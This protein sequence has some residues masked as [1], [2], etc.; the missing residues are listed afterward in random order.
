MV[1]HCPWGQDAEGPEEVEA[2]Q[3]KLSQVQ[4]TRK[5]DTRWQRPETVKQVTGRCLPGSAQPSFISRSWQVGP[6]RAGHD[7]VVTLSLR[8]P[9]R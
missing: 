3:G 9:S 8:L 2:Q 5:D 7:C 4:G 1:A 6:E